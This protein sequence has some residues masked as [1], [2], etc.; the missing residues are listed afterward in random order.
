MVTKYNTEVNT[1]T[2]VFNLKRLLGQVFQLLPLREEDKDWIK[3]L[4]TLENELCGLVALVPDL[5]EGL[6]VVSK[7]QGMLEKGEELEFLEFR[8]N[9]FECCSLLSFVI[10]SVEGDKNEE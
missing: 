7:L 5:K 9:I 8:R 10:N 1:E 6:S 2:L 4:Q 3:P